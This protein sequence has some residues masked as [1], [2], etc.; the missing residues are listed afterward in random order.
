V[1]ILAKLFGAKSQTAAKPV[2]HAVIVAFAYIGSTDLEPL[3]ALERQLESRI[4]AAGQVSTTAM[5]LQLMEAT[6]LSTCMG[7]QPTAC[8]SVKCGLPPKI[9]LE[10]GDAIHSSSR[11]SARA[12]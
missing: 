8:S 10:R 7:R 12:G 2:E 4:A 1:G 3:F 6:A 5:R 11:E 9:S